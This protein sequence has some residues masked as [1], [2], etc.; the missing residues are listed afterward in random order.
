MPAYILRPC[1]KNGNRN[2]SRELAAQQQA[3]Q[4]LIVFLFF[5]RRGNFQS[6]YQLSADT[7]TVDVFA[8][9]EKLNNDLAQRFLLGRQAGFTKITC[10]IF[11]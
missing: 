9:A 7:F 4:T 10:D 5:G 11:G 6:S 8:C 2:D 1:R 3:D